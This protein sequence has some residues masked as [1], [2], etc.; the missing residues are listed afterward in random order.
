MPRMGTSGKEKWKTYADVFD[1][2]TERKIWSLI[3]K[4]VIDG[5]VGQ[6]S[7][8]K[9]ANI[10]T[11]EKD[12]KPVIVKIYRLSTCD[13][14]RMYSFIRTDP[15]FAELNRQRRKVVF[16]WAKREYRNLMKTREAGV[17]VP[18]PIAYLSNVLV[19]EFIGDDDAAPKLK[20]LTPKDKDAFMEDLINQMRIIHKAGLVHGDLSPF[21]VLNHN[22]KPVIIDLSQMTTLKDPNA[23]D[24]FERDVRNIT[25][26]AKKIGL[27]ITESELAQ[28]VKA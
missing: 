2:F 1:S 13:F 10:F 14:N 25:N 4:K 21:N 22:E 23:K 17:R 28:K 7:I 5:L 3:S 12:G 24:Y 16:A 9:E 20:D 15:R 8:G 11:A 27:S 6:V 26:Y 19:L 18:I